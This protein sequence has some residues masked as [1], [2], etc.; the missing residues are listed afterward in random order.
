VNGAAGFFDEASGVT[1]NI[2]PRIDQIL[3]DGSAQ[4][5]NIETAPTAAR[6]LIPAGRPRLSDQAALQAQGVLSGRF[7]VMIYLAFLLASQGASG[8]S[9]WPVPRRTAQGPRRWRCS[10]GCAAGSRAISGSRP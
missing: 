7:F 10:S 8:A 5:F 1:T 2:G 9:S 4:L 3:I 6:L